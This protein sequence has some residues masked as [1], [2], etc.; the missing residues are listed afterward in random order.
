MIDL[1]IRKDNPV[2][3][4]V[5]FLMIFLIG[6]AFAGNIV[7]VGNSIEF[8][9]T[10]VGYDNFTSQSSQTL[11]SIGSGISSSTFQIY[12]DTWLD[13]NESSDIQIPYSNSMAFINNSNYTFF[14]ELNCSNNISYS[15]IFNFGDYGTSGI[16]FYLHIGRSFGIKNMKDT[17]ISRFYTEYLKKESFLACSYRGLNNSIVCYNDT[18]IA[19]SAGSDFNWSN[20]LN[21]IS[22]NR[23]IG[24]KGVQNYSGAMNYIG[25]VN[26]TLSSFQLKDIQQ[27]QY[28]NNYTLNKTLIVN[29][30][31]TFFLVNSTL[32]YFVTGVY[33]V[34]KSTD[35]GIS[36]NVIYAGTNYKVIRNIFRDS[37]GT[38]FVGQDHTGGMMISVGNESNWT[39]IHPF[40]CNASG[41]EGINGTFWYMDEAK[42]GSLIL[43]EYARGG[44][45]N[46]PVNCSFIHKST[47]G[48]LTWTI[49]YNST[50]AGHPGR[51]IH[52]V[53][54]DP[55]T[56]K[57]YASQG[58]SISADAI[59]RS[60]D[61]G[62]TWKEIYNGS[63]QAQ[64]ISIVFTPTC[65]IF[66]SDDY[67]I[68]T[69]LKTCD[70]T[71][72][73]EVYRTYS[74]TDG[75]FW[76]MSRDNLTGY[77]I[78]GLVSINNE[79]VA[80]LISPDNGTHW[81]STEETIL[82]TDEGFSHIS[83]FDE[84]G[85]AFYKITATGL[86]GS[87]NTYKFNFNFPTTYKYNLLYNFNENSGSTAY[88]SSGN[89]NNGIISGATWSN[90]GI[91]KALAN[92]VDYSLNTATGLFTI[93][94]T[95][96]LYSW[97]ISNYQ[98][99]TQNG[100]SV[101]DSV[102]IKLIATVLIIF[103]IFMLGWFIKN[104]LEE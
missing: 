89:G 29:D 68:T 58:D 36:Y 26:Y 95:N 11:S 17:T 64:P 12:N 82:L 63:L 76:S 50:K 10:N 1:E 13:F 73:N 91:L 53:A 35:G 98:Y 80:L 102:L 100:D 48:G 101:L 70:D 30:Y 66:G 9:T 84:K 86:S 14:M 33:N 2:V 87:P 37:R 46:P 32:M 104:K 79:N 39:F 24:K 3:F 28:L 34:S 41:T 5:I 38:F 65:R 61:N 40:V 15:R 47:D 57:I 55:Y 54:T 92:G 88:D 60:D 85:Y 19:L 22:N 23:S 20:I 43:G 16:G 83:Q 31:S 4:L 71:N 21:S 42:D 56:G 67:L 81:F 90:D 6:L 75:N 69:I 44:G 51:H 93:L 103:F 7:D 97:I 45:T 94:N 62:T 72:F 25:L 78:A 99:T 74:D 96:Y 8:N 27:S 18:G 59:L 77:I 52:I 49:V